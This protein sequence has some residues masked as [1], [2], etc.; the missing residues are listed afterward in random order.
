MWCGERL[1]IFCRRSF[2]C[3]L[4]PPPSE[5]NSERDA[6]DIRVTDQRRQ[7]RFDIELR[8]YTSIGFCARTDEI[9]YQRLVRTTVRTGDVRETIA[10]ETEL[11]CERSHSLYSSIVRPSVWSLTHNPPFSETQT[12]PLGATG[13]MHSCSQMSDWEP[14]LLPERTRN[15]P[16][17]YDKV[18]IDMN[19]SPILDFLKSTSMKWDWIRLQTT[20]DA[21]ET[22]HIKM[23]AAQCA[24]EPIYPNEM[25]LFNVLMY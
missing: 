2:F 17:A 6:R 8:A 21:N 14:M 1:D 15:V 12:G 19:T 10:N 24:C 5:K 3:C 22:H 4:R 7:C 11:N 13:T 20:T 9:F 23:T 25:F 16:S 18:C